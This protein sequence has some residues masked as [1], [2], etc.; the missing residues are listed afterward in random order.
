MT[1]DEMVA[2]LAW[3]CTVWEYADD[4]CEMTLMCP[5]CGSIMR[6]GAYVPRSHVARHSDQELRQALLELM[7]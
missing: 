2:K 4:G 5:I 7:I 6:Q 1:R 3:S